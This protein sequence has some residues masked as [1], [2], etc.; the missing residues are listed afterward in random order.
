MK[1]I[2]FA[3]LVFIPAVLSAQPKHGQARIDSLLNE[4][5]GRK[6]DSLRIAILDDICFD[7]YNIN[8]DSGIFYGKQGLQLAEKM[9]LSKPTAHLYYVLGANYCVKSDYSDALDSWLMALKLFEER[10]NKKGIANTLTN[11]GRIYVMQRN[12]NH[13]LEYYNKSLYTYIS[14][15]DT[16]NIAITMCEIGGAYEVQKKLPKSAR[17]LQPGAGN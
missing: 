12:T 17:I 11:I 15:K 14:L 16:F 5:N 1:K 10:G 13:A 2:V 8:P 3:L 6:H 4:L 9:N 7:Y